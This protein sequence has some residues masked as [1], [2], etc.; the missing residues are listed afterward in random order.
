MLNMTYLFIL[1]GHEREKEAEEKVEERIKDLFLPHRGDSTHE[2][3]QIHT[4]AHA[5]IRPRKLSQTHTRTHCCN[6]CG[7]MHLKPRV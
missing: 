7:E 1:C 3:A 5:H 2:C 4:D 6:F